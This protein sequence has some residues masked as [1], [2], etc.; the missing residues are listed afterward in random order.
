MIIQ[1][2]LKGQRYY[3]PAVNPKIDDMRV[4]AQGVLDQGVFCNWYHNSGGKIALTDIAARLNEADLHLHWNDYKGFGKTSPFIS[5]TAGSIER[6]PASAQN[7]PHPAKYRALKFATQGWKVSGIVIYAYVFVLGKKSV[8]FQQFAEEIR[9]LNLYT[10]YSA[11]QLQGEVTAKV[12]IPPVQIEKIEI[13]M[14]TTVS[15][16][17]SNQYFPLDQPDD[18]LLQNS[19]RYIDPVVCGNVREVI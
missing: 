5:T 6:D 10:Q 17:L 4:Y 14:Q 7:I 19:A 18:V 1:K 8:Q 11:Y 2:V 16:A 13:W 3:G 15:A 12:H 9:E